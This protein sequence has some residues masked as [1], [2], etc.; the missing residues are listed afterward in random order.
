MG[1]MIVEGEG[2][3]LGEGEFGTSHCNQGDFRRGS[4]QISVVRLVTIMQKLHRKH[5]YKLQKRNNLSKKP[6]WESPLKGYVRPRYWLE[7]NHVIKV[8]R[9]HIKS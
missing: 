3:V 2:A 9:G 6:S 5:D 7:F 4:Y 8:I 1:V